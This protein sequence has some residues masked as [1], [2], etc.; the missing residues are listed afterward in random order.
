M[1]VEHPDVPGQEAGVPGA[2]KP[3]RPVVERLYTTPM[4]A[5]F[6]VRAEHEVTDEAFAAGR[7]A[8]RGEY[9]A[10]CGVVF[11]PVPMDAPPGPP[12][13]VCLSVVEAARRAAAPP[14]RPRHRRGGLLRRLV[15]RAQR[16]QASTGNDT[17]R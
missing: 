16:H 14:H 11:V 7:A 17:T 3:G 10:V 13:P 1:Q 9:E 5:Q 12:C 4:T 15:P 8:G 6:G 2:G